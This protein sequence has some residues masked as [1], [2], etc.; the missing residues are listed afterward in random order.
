MCIVIKL[1]LYIWKY[2]QLDWIIISK[3]TLFLISKWRVN[4]QIRRCIIS[5]KPKNRIWIC[6]RMYIKILIQEFK[7]GS[8]F[9][10]YGKDQWRNCCGRICYFFSLSI[11]LFH[12]Y[13]GMYY[14]MMKQALN[15]LKWSAFIVI[16]RNTYSS[17]T[18]RK[19]H[20]IAGSN[21]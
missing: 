19:D 13:I 3:S 21:R 5:T 2:F 11:M 7:H 4:L 10:L 14:S 6:S 20:S 9:S 12:F 18:D 1:W 17:F 8:I 15:I 16:S